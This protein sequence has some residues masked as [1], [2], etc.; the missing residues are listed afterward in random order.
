MEKNKFSE[1]I[2]LL[3]DERNISQL[4]ETLYVSL[5]KYKNNS[6]LEMLSLVEGFLGN[7]QDS[8][9]LIKGLGDER[10]KNNEYYLFLTGPIKEKYLPKYNVFIE[11]WESKED[12]EITLIIQELEDIFSN[13]ELYHL[14][15]LIYL[16][17]N[18]LQEAKKYLEK[19]LKIDILN[20]N[21]L[22]IKA[23]ILELEQERSQKPKK[24]KSNVVV[25]A[26]ALIF[27]AFSTYNYIEKKGDS[28]LKDQKISLLNTENSSYKNQ[29]KDLEHRIENIGNQEK[30]VTVTKKNQ[31]KTLENDFTPRE[32]FL[33]G[34]ELR[35]EKKYDKSIKYLEISMNNSPKNS[36]YNR[37]AMFWLGRSYQDSDNKIEAIKIFEKYQSDYLETS[38]YRGEVERRLKKLNLGD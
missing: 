3:I 16:K 32:L 5:N 17:K 9:N 25:V 30:I 28:N 12:K 26:A 36:T 27:F 23:S 10:W 2:A 29:L 34:K 21:L 15:C 19:G 20:K 1:E 8:L 35:K 11:S 37:E 22:K 18:N 38:I 24:N 13:I 33:K 14:G 6:I 31:E 4:R 7:F